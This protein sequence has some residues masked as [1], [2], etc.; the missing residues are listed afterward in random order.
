MSVRRIENAAPYQPQSAVDEERLPRKYANQ[1]FVLVHYP[2]AWF[3]DDDSDMFLPEPSEIQG[4]QGVNGIG[5]DGDMRRAL[6]GSVGK[7]G[8]VIH[9]TDRRLGPWAG[10]VVRYKC[11]G[12]GWHYTLRGAVFD[13]LPN[14]NAVPVDGSAGRRKFLRHL[15]ESGIVPPIDEPSYNMLLEREQRQAARLER[16]AT[17]LNG[18]AYRAR[19]DARQA[20]ILKM[21]AAWNRVRQAEE[22]VPASDRTQVAA[23]EV[24][25]P[26]ANTEMPAS[27]RP[28][29]AR[30]GKLQI[31]SAS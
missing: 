8:I 14:G 2:T 1:P 12:G 21:I 27:G 3:Y 16:N 28:S 6:A 15:V 29:K 10:Y 31:G 7:G 25:D 19:A 22:N 5:E 26:L 17:N 9:P 18:E 4:K 11:E 13:K 24:V 23:P 20:R 30:D